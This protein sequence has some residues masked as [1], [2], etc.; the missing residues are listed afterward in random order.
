MADTARDEDG[1]ELGLTGSSL[2]L[3]TRTYF[4]KKDTQNEGKQEWFE[5]KHYSIQKAQ[6]RYVGRGEQ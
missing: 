3:T 4:S 6:L 2:P 5:C 1:G